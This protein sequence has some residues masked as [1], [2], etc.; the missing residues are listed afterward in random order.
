MKKL[1]TASVLLLVIAALPLSHLLM[2]GKEKVVICHVTKSNFLFDSGHK[3][4][5][6]PNALEAHLNHGS[7]CQ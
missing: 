4:N 7:S 5:V 2:A 1:L 6:S 3:I